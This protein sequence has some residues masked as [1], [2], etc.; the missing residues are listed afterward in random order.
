M[1]QPYVRPGHAV[2]HYVGVYDGHEPSECGKCCFPLCEIYRVEGCSGLG[3][4]CVWSAFTV[5]FGAVSYGGCSACGGALYMFSFWK[6][7][8][9]PV[10]NPPN[11]MMK[12]LCPLMEVWRYEKNPCD[13]GGDCGPF[14]F[15]GIFCGLHR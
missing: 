4:M 5:C 3:P 10:T 8:F 6:P 2:R 13:G 14:I 7:N 11:P 9:K 15:P 12:L 1:Q